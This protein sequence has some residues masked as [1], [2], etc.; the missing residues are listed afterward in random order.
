MKKVLVTG[1]SGFIGSAVVRQ[2]IA[3]TDVIVINVDKLTYAG[4]L[5]SLP[6]LLGHP[7][8]V[9]EQL[10]IC[11]AKE[12]A[13]VFAQNQPDGVMHLATESLPGVTQLAPS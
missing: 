10:D 12:V 11:D 8:Q 9:F 6:G 13:R 1:G 4:N 2:F 7:R 5:D 3:E